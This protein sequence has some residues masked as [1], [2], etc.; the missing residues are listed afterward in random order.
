MR[1]RYRRAYL[2]AP[3][4]RGIERAA[5]L[6]RVTMTGPI[7]IAA[8]KCNKGHSLCHQRR[9]VVAL[10]KAHPAPVPAPPSKRASTLRQSAPRRA[11]RRLG[12]RHKCPRR[13]LAP[14]LSRPEV[15]PTRRARKSRV[16]ACVHSTHGVKA[17]VCVVCAYARTRG[18]VA[19]PAPRQTR[20][21]SPC[22]NGRRNEHAR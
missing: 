1:R 5:R 17:A 4:D 9:C 14:G 13:R 15:D 21:Q 2:A 16:H 18:R 12:P 10:D 20:R 7:G 6:G 19:A 22:V 8:S 3:S 11:V